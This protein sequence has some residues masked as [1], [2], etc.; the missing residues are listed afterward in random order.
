LLAEQCCL[1]VHCN[2]RSSYFSGASNCCMYSIDA[3]HNRFIQLVCTQR[4]LMQVW[5]CRQLRGGWG[6]A[7]AL[8]PDAYLRKEARVT[9]T[10]GISGITTSTAPCPHLS[11]LS[12]W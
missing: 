11:M 7:K 12:C 6:A 9:P 2:S 3:I 8:R 4:T 10:D 5:K 1:M